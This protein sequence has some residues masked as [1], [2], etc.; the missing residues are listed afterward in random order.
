MIAAASFL[1]ALAVIRARQGCTR[2]KVLAF[3]HRFEEIPLV[4]HLSIHFSIMR[5]SK[6]TGVDYSALF[7]NFIL[8]E[9]ERFRDTGMLVVYL[10]SQPNFVLFR[11]DHAEKTLNNSV[12]ISKGNAYNL[13]LPWLGEGLL[14]SSGKKWK[15]R[16]RLLTPAFHFQILEEFSHVINHQAAIFIEQVAKKSRDEDIV[17]YVSAATLDIVCETIMGVNLNSQTTGA[18]KKYLHSIKALGELFFKR[19]QS[20]AK[21]INF[22]YE[23]TGDGR[24]NVQ[25]LR[26]LHEFTLKVINDRKKELEDNPEELEKIASTDGSMLKSKKPFLDVL[27]VEHMKNKNL[28][29]DDIRE[30]VDTFMFEGHDTTSMGITWAVYLLG[31][32]SE[33]Q[34]RIFEEIDSVFEGDHT[35]PVTTEHLKQL[36]YL[37]MA[38]KETQRI[39]PSVPII[40]RKVTT[41]YELLGKPIPVDSEVNI[42]IIGMHRDPRAFPQP[43]LFIPERFLPEESAK[44]SPFAFIPFSAGPR[45]CIGQRFALMEEKIII[46]W[47]LRRFRLKSLVP[48]DEIHMVAEMVLR[49]KSEIKVECI[50]RSHETK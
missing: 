27:L 41:E 7:L 49:P 45:N 39:Y 19:V 2:S 33:V 20:P 5:T 14:T 35:G 17:P 6:A 38:L 48:R 23:M 34:E 47:L 21:W 12:N 16:R 9:M 26:H 30:E 43:E 1:V 40:A 24:K 3:P 8:G 32:H 44:R 15:T 10:G 4:S 22:I 42:N 11:A 28:T 31:L 13:L 36:R 18:G 50:P 29:V 25:Y 37:D 46:V